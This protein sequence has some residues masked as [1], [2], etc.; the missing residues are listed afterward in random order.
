MIESMYQVLRPSTSNWVP[1][2]GCQYHVRQ[3]GTPTP[4]ATPLVLAHGGAVVKNEADNLLAVF[5]AGASLVQVA[6]PDAALLDR[7][8]VTEKVTRDLSR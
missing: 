4:G 8:R 1:L 2:R 7:R 6:N 3:W 5:A